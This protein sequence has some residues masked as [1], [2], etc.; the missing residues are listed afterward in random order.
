MSNQTHYRSFWG[1][2]FTGQMTQST[3]SKHRRK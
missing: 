1:T 2:V 3:V